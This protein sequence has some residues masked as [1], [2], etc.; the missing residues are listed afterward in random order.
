MD[1]WVEIH[2]HVS[3]HVQLHQQIISDFHTKQTS[4]KDEKGLGTRLKV[5]EKLTRKQ[6]V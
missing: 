5:A 2:N 3:N 4:E 1:E 6:G